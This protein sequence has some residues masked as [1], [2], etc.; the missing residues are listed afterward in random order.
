MLLL[1]IPSALPSTFSRK[2]CSEAQ[3]ISERAFSGGAI[4]AAMQAQ[5]SAC[6]VYAIFRE[7]A[8]RLE[9]VSEG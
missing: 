9:F 3:I 4:D 8:L 7:A 2:C 6:S 1:L 5:K